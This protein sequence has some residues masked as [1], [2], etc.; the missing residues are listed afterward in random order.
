MRRSMS[1]ATTLKWYVGL[2][3]ERNRTKSSSSALANSTLPKTASSNDVLP[4]SGTANRTAAGSPADF[5][6]EASAGSNL[7]QVPSY[8]G[9]Q[10]ASAASTRRFSNSSFLQ[11]Q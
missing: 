5:R 7:R 8:L 3:S 2:P 1:S 6:C 11:K 10:P 9:G 4:P